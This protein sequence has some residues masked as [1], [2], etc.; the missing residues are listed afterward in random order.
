[1][2]EQRR[3]PPAR[4]GREIES[5]YG[6]G[7]RPLPRRSYH[8]RYA[9]RMDDGAAGAGGRLTGLLLALAVAALVISQGLWQVTAPA[10]AGRILRAVL[11]PLTDLD[12]TLAANRDAIREIGAGQPEGGTV[13]V[14]GLPIRV[15]IPREQALNAEPAALRAAALTSMSETLYRQ[16]ATAFR[17]P[18]AAAPEPSIL[19]SQ[20]ALRGTLNI[21]TA[22]RHATYT[23]ARLIAGI[24]TLLLAGLTIVLQEGPA[25]LLGPGASVLAGALVAAFAA[26]G[27]WVLAF[28]FFGGEDVV[29]DIARRV[30]RDAAVTVALVAA[31][32]AVLGLLVTALGL[33]ARRLDQVEPLP[34]PARPRPNGRER[35]E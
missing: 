12:Q 4:R 24:V 27:A 25:R 33:L 1:M 34:P 29:D 23:N 30:A 11:P 14:P 8:S 18:D 22:E 17:A 9:A 10:P 5:P 26:L 6:Y 16:G 3:P 20:W 31:I 21:L 2:T 13:V 15:E 35:G 19:S 28:L 7:R 32:F